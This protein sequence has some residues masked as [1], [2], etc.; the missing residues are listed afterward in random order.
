MAISP[1]GLKLGDTTENG[2]EFY[3]LTRQ[4][5]TVQYLVSSLHM[6]AVPKLL[7]TLKT[8]MRKITICL[9]HLH[10]DYGTKSGCENVNNM[11]P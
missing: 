1:F 6:F 2:L 3:W 10:L 11:C 9:L 5:R 7:K 8:V 4:L